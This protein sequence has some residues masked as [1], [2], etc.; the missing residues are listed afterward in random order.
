[1]A[2]L[3]GSIEQT[4]GNLLNT[5]QTNLNGMPSSVTSLLAPQQT[6]SLSP[7][8]FS[9]GPNDK[10]IAKDIYGI[11]TTAPV[12]AVDQF[13]A[14]NNTNIISLFTSANGISNLSGLIS[15]NGLG[16]SVNASVLTSRVQG[17]L[18]GFS[19]SFQSLSPNLLSGA[20]GNS[21]LSL[22]RFPEITTNINGVVSN[23]NTSNLLGAQ[24]LINMVNS[25][26]GNPSIASYMDVGASSALMAVVMREAIS[27]NVGGAVEALVGSAT[28]SDVASN[29]LRANA[30]YAVQNCDMGTIQ[31]IVTSLGPGYISAAAPNSATQMLTS[32][33]MPAG[34]TAAQYSSLYTTL[35]TLL[36]QVQPGWDTVNRNGAS[37]GALAPFQAIS[38]DARTLFNSQNAYQTEIAI[39]GNYP[40]VD[41]VDQAKKQYPFMLVTPKNSTYVTTNPA[42]VGN[43]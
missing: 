3:V 19:G 37:V 6:A 1:M 12:N 22:S 42:F 8:L 29:A 17:A 10:L 36:G 13:F 41:L 23:L 7:S 33:R 2:S 40:S 11:D 34:S 25:I 9:T 14:K 16:L 18:S 35:T 28:N 5:V 32:Y 21:S 30:A 43:A 24:D 20:L 31:Q 39:A 26:T 27:Q 4:V 15:G 38:P